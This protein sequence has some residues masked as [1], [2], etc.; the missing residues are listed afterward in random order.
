MPEGDTAGPEP[1]RLPVAYEIEVVEIPSDSEAGDEVEPS[2]P[3]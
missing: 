2:A 3:S 1:E